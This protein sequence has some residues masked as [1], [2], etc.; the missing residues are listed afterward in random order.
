MFATL[1]KFGAASAKKTKTAKSAMKVRAFSSRSSVASPP[2]A[3]EGRALASELIA[4]LPCRPPRRAASP[5][6]PARGASRLR[7]AKAL[8]RCLFMPAP[9]ASRQAH[10]R[11]PRPRR[12]PPRPPRAPSNSPVIRPF[13]ITR[14]RSDSAITSSRSEVTNRMPSPSAASR[15]I[16]RKT[17]AL[18]PTSMPRDGS[19]ISSTFGF[20]ISALPMTTFCWLP[21]DSALIGFSGLATLIASSRTKS[22]TR[23]DLRRDVQVEPAGEVAERRQRQVLATD[24]IWIGAERLAVLRDQRDAPRDPPGDVLRLRAARRREGTARSHAGAAP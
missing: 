14:M 13:D 11:P 8:A 22:F 3:G 23:A 17:S 19:S 15:R 7:S 4:S 20:V 9:P 2:S 12:S 24:M 21:P 10:A 16:S 6:S 1:R 5:A 18:A